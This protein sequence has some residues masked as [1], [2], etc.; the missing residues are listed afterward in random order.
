M[1]GD[2]R[3]ARAWPAR[4]PALAL[5]LGVWLSA[6]APASAE[7]SFYNQFGPVSTGVQAGFSL[8]C[9][10]DEYVVGGGLQTTGGY[11]ETWVNDSGPYDSV[12]QDLK[13]DDGW[14][15]IVDNFGGET[16]TVSAI[17]ICTDKKPRYRTEPFEVNDVA[18]VATCPG[19]SVPIGGGVSTDGAFAD[20]TVV[21]ESWPADTDDPG[22]R[23]DSWI[24]RGSSPTSSVDSPAAV[25]VICQKDGKRPRYRRSPEVT[26]FAMTGSNDGVECKP[27]E[28]GLGGGIQNTSALVYTSGMYPPD[29]GD[30]DDF[31]DDGFAGFVDNTLT[32]DRVFFV[33][34]VCR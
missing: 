9:A 5:T 20:R 10:S 30:A 3:S 6:T 28:R 25:T 16:E 27:G 23:K 13:R 1:Q 31:P 18:G 22:K 8:A 21:T 4:W 11:N 33:H 19:R 24:G 26:A 29:G 32:F 15:G 7:L 34:A 14:E 12:D 2:S 17:A